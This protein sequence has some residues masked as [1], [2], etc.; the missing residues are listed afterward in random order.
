MPNLTIFIIF[1]EIEFIENKS[2]H[3]AQLKET[4]SRGQKITIQDIINFYKI[5]EEQIKRSTID[6]RIY[7][8]TKKGVLHRVARGTYSLSKVEINKFAPNIDRSLKNLFG[9]VRNHFPYIDTCLWTTKWLSEFMLHQPG[10]YY[11]ILEVERDAMVVVFHELRNQG[12]EVFL[13]PSEEMLNNYVINAKKTIIISKLTT[14]APTEKIDAVVTTSI[15]KMLVDI[16][17]DPDLYSAYQGAEMKRIYRSA[18]EK[19][20]INEPKMLRYAN[21]R[22]KK[23]EI[24]EL[25]HKTKE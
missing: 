22:A 19:Y 9:K 17:C 2:L 7:E 18:F 11:T 13:D 10:K 21:R 8:L 20:R 24:E 1:V 23:T 3:I 15:E 14:E 4:F 6:K 16:Y 5:Y 12:K 25:I